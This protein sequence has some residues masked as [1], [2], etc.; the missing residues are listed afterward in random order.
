MAEGSGAALGTAQWRHW[1][2]EA[3]ENARYGK[4]EWMAVARKD[5]VLKEGVNSAA[6]R[7]PLK[8]TQM[9]DTAGA[10]ATMMDLL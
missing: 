7:G 5:E 9:K 10:P 2:K 4:R 3:G 8:E 1:L 6:Q